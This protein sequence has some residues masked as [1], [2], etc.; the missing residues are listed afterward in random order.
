MSA[1]SLVSLD[2]KRHTLTEQLF[3]QVI[4]HVVT[5]GAYFE[6]TSSSSMYAA[7]AE[8]VLS[9]D[10]MRTGWR[11]HFIQVDWKPANSYTYQTSL[12]V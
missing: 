11:N 6:W 3:Q 9:S 5:A 12:H 8:V 4:E 1:W 2:N 10:G 7:E